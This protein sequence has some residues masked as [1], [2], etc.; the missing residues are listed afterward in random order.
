MSRE[1]G[2]RKLMTRAPNRFC[3]R[4]IVGEHVSESSLRRE[5][6]LFGGKREFR[7]EDIDG[8]TFCIG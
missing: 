8:G 7:E 5:N 2:T 3:S 6:I 4:Y 1:F